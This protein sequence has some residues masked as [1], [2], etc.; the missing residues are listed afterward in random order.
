MGRSGAAVCVGC[1]GLDLS[2]KW[3]LGVK[4]FLHAGAVGS[5]AYLGVFVANPHPLSPLI[6]KTSLRM[7]M[8]R[9]DLFLFPIEL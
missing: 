2:I 1:L 5:G 6:F 3:P 7:W 4:T 8:S 9:F